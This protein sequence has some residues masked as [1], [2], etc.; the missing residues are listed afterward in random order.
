MSTYAKLIETV[1]R[2]NRTV[3]EQVDENEIAQFIEEI[4]RARSIQLF[5][6]GRMQVSVRAFAMRL[7]HMGFDAHVV[8][9]TLTPR[10]GPGDLL[11]VNCGVTAVSLNIIKLAKN[12][13]AK[14]CV[15]T[16][17][18]ENEHGRLADFTVKVPG[19]IFGLQ[20]EVS[21]IQPM[22]SLL[23]QSLLLF[24]DI[25]VL[26]IMERYGITAEE[27]AQRHTNLEG[28]DTEFA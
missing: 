16:A 27:M 12:T 19:Q 10:I 26:M 4:G 9:D 1:I 7:M 11:V 2:E 14:I 5:A 3:L 20:G 15:V 28:I 17:H 6:M 24:E 18:P 13:G 25:V 22:A 21:S 23:E 8:Y